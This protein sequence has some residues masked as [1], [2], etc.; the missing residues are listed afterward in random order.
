MGRFLPVFASSV[1]A[2]IKS[3]RTLFMKAA[4]PTPP[5]VPSV[6]RFLARTRR[7]IEINQHASLSDEM[8]CNSLIGL[9]NAETNWINSNGLCAKPAIEDAHRAQRFE[10]TAGSGVALTPQR[11]KPAFKKKAGISCVQRQQLVTIPFRVTPCA[12]RERVVKRG[13]GALNPSPRDCQACENRAEHF[14]CQAPDIEPSPRGDVEEG[15][16]YL[17]SATRSTCI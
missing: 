15:T 13:C 11:K 9:L 6:H 17:M 4:I 3:V 5:R 1:L 10:P 7:D 8:I 16:Q 14:T 2:K 12:C